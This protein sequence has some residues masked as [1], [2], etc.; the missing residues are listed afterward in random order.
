MGIMLG[1]LTSTKVPDLSS[2]ASK[3]NGNTLFRLLV[4]MNL[5]YLMTLLCELENKITVFLLL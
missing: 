2:D 1:Q 3:Q 4:L 5:K